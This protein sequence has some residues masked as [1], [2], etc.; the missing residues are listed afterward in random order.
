MITNDIFLQHR[1]NASQPPAR[2]IDAFHHGRIETTPQE[3]HSLHVR[4][5]RQ[6]PARHFSQWFLEKREKDPI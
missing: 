2:A 3:E 5:A 4:L 1:R 6:D